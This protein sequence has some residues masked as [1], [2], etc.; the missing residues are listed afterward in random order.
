MIPRSN[1]GVILIVLGVVVGVFSRY[2]S[3]AQVSLL[4]A[5]WGLDLTERAQQFVMWV[6]LI[7]AAGLI[8]FGTYLVLF[9]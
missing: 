3:S 8:L 2:S 1:E 5:V 9:S 4:K 7:M 6:Y